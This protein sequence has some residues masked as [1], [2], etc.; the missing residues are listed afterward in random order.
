MRFFGAIFQTFLT[1][2]GQIGSL[3]ISK[4]VFALKCDLVHESML[5]STPQLG[6][7]LYYLEEFPHKKGATF[8][9][10][11]NPQKKTTHASWHIPLN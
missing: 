8:W 5:A 1:I 3:L 6:L 2:G 7:L 9:T 4:I 10:L 11:A